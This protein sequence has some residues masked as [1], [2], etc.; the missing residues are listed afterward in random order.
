MITR[1]LADELHRKLRNFPILVILGPRQSGKTTFIRNALADWRYLDLEKPSDLAPL[2]SDPERRLEQLG[3]SVIF[4]EAQR[5]PQIFPLLRSVVDANRKR[6][7][8]F[9][10]LGSASPELVR[11]VSETLAG[12]AAFIE[13]TPFQWQEVMGTRNVTLDSFWLKGGF[14]N[15]F[16][17]RDPKAR[18]DWYEG[19]TQT[20]LERDLPAL[21]LSVS[22]VQMRKLWGMLA[23]AHGNLWNASQFGASMGIN[24]HTV[25]RYA[26]ILE[27]TYLIRRLQPFHANIGKRLTKSPK[28]YLRDTGILHYFLGIRDRETLDVYPSRGA[29]WEG[30]LLE[31]LAALYRQAEPQARPYF[32]RTSGGAE[33]DLLMDLGNRQVPFEFKLNSAPNSSDL[34]GLRNCMADLG[35]RKGY[36][37]YPGKEDY[38]LGNGIEALAA[39]G[40]LAKPK[41]LTTL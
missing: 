2:Q 16:L 3:D 4:D 13:V 6:N 32:W 29:S 20:F 30:F 40:L 33:V 14:P 26:D 8:R 36:V 10:L 22:P 18:W 17:F 7:G 15:A 28:I 19:Y 31:Q 24:Y 5:L 39:E 41:R 9:V 37:V 1:A 38:S 25:N 34:K 11:G 12:R 35:I 23:H 27:H 21:G